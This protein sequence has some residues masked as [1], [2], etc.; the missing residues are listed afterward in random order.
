MDL[1]KGYLAALSKL[2]ELEGGYEKYNLDTG[3]GLSVFDIIHE[4][5]AE[6]GSKLPY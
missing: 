2:F 1:S 6:M 5:E 4:F 3:K